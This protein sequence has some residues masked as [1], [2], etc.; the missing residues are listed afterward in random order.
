MKKNIHIVLFFLL[1]S[2]WAS[3]QRSNI[4]K[5]LRY[6]QSGSLDTAKLFIDSVS[7]H[8]ETVNLTETW[9]YRGFVYKEIFNKDEKDNPLSP[10]RDE[11]ISSFFKSLELDP[12]TKL[13][14]GTIK[15]I[16]YLTTTLYNHAAVMLN[17]D[18]YKIA[19]INFEKYKQLSQK[20]EPDSTIKEIDIQFNLVLGTVYTQLYED[21]R[22]KNKSFFDKSRDVYLYVLELE[23]NNISANYNLG[24]LYYNDAVNII[25]GLDYELDLITLELV[26]GDC[27]ELF[28]K[29]LP[30]MQRAYELNPKKKDTL[31]GLSGIYFSLN[32]FEKSEQ[33]KKEL[34]L[35]NVSDE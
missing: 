18:D 5:A 30:Y 27:V 21:D 16:K 2:G 35:L 22:E 8:P 25:K 9:Y 26:Q 28:K 12:E 1:I 20:I 4:S 23:P 34:E 14:E 19:L 33:V 31:V 6:Y 13:K 11:A 17:P 29:S 10:A 32:E 15:S 7:V 24:I 3:A